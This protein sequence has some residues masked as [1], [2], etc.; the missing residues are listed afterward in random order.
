MY[1]L[2]RDKVDPKLRDRRL[3]D[4]VALLKYALR[5]C[6]W[7]V[8]TGRLFLLEHPSSATSWSHRDTLKLLSDPKVVAVIGHQ[9]AHELKLEFGKYLR[10]STKFA[11]NGH[12]MSE[13]LKLRCDGSHEHVP[14][15]GSHNGVN[16]S[17]LAQ[18]WT[19]LMCE[20]I[21]K[22]FVADFQQIDSNVSAD[23]DSNDFCNALGKWKV[24]IT[25]PKC[26]E[27][28]FGVIRSVYNLQPVHISKSMSSLIAQAPSAKYYRYA[29]TLVYQTGK[30]QAI[31]LASERERNENVA[32]YPAGRIFVRVYFEGDRD[33]GS[34]MKQKRK[35]HMVGAAATDGTHIADA[36]TS[37]GCDSQTESDFD[38]HW[39]GALD[40]PKVD[41]DGDS[42][43]DLPNVKDE[44]P[45]GSIDEAYLKR[46][47]IEVKRLHSNLGHPSKNALV[48]MLVHGGAKKEAID[49]A[50]KLECQICK[51]NEKPK[52]QRPAKMPIAYEFNEVVGI[53][54]IHLRGLRGEKGLRAFCHITDWAT[55]K[56]IALPIQVESP[57]E[58]WRVVREWINWYGVP[59]RIVYDEHGS[60]GGA[61]GDNLE[62]WGIRGWPISSDSPWQTVFRWSKD[63]RETH[64][65][66]NSGHGRCWCS[67][68]N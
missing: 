4:A 55:S 67:L 20:R 9:C 11:T 32:G 31:E 50:R 44:G 27:K 60:F 57:E 8:S 59:K 1:L 41:I 36:T 12:Y 35:V 19:P 63:L 42:E 54:C 13:C 52:L 23:L 30:W 15:E 18:V 64:L 3:K 38:D 7:A 21:A 43:A 22:S 10:K 39:I 28:R 49:I 37:A 58:C 53:D 45:K 14:I 6:R 46:L 2:N 17:R 68:R 24:S 56:Q 5:V 29:S 65:S 62:R 33:M 34:H 26:A 16:I 47:N 61:F 66:H 25:N 51:S 40:D 48:R